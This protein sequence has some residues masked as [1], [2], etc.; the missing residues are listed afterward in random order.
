MTFVRKSSKN[1]AVGRSAEQTTELI[2]SDTK[3]SVSE[4]S[5]VEK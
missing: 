1:K 5:E 2:D 4:E 3:A